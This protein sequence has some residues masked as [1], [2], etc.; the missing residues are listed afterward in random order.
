MCCKGD[1]FRTVCRHCKKPEPEAADDA[2]FVPQ[3][4]L[5]WGDFRVCGDLNKQNQKLYTT[6]NGFAAN[7]K[8]NYI[9]WPLEVDWALLAVEN[10]RVEN[11]FVVFFV[12]FRVPSV[13]SIEFERVM[14]GK[15]FIQRG[16]GWVG[17]MGIRRL[18]P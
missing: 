16:F 9:G 4:L 6:E 13:W 15:L 2:Q 1:L 8:E 18:C 7:T 17:E 14:D 3:H 12:C 5:W 11:A 10:Y